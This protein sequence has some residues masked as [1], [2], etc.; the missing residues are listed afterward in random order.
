[1]TLGHPERIIVSAIVTAALDVTTK[2][3]PYL[4]LTFVIYIAN[5][6]SSATV[7][8]TIL[9]DTLSAFPASKISV[10]VKGK[11]TQRIQMPSSLRCYLSSLQFRTIL[12]LDGKVYNS[13]GTTTTQFWITVGHAIV[14]TKTH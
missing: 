8:Q 9:W 11:E 4:D 2:E 1:L 10:Y 13:L 12:K 6:P 3:S 7:E 14:M 5:D